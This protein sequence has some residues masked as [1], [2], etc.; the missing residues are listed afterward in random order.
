M[1]RERVSQ[2][3]IW[4]ALAARSVP[5]VRSLL[6]RLGLPCAL[7][8]SALAAGTLV[9]GGRAVHAASRPV[10]ARGNL[11][12]APDHAG[13]PNNAIIA[14]KTRRPL[15]ALTF[16]DGPDPRYTPAVLRLLR[17]NHAHATFFVIGE[18]VRAHRA[19]GRAT[20]AAGN[21]LADHTW[22]H[23]LLP[24]LGDRALRR[25]VAAGQRELAVAGLP[26]SALFRPP[27]G[28]FDAR[29]SRVVARAGLR[30]I[31]WNQVVERELRRART[32]SQAAAA[33]A[34]KVT[35][36]S[37]ILAHDGRHNRSRTVAMIARLLPA[38]RARGLRVVTVSRLLRAAADRPR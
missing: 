11:L 13:D 18:R 29:V 22:S 15:V 12:L 14:V 24:P 6:L 5:R 36:G 23:A 25:E 2:P 10:L 1:P 21:E 19:L 37:I 26:E 34:S 20:A 8:A 4:L 30:V 31:G 38:L 16:D 32:V 7:L 27:H 9:P 3:V 33:L 17:A 28:Y 35:P